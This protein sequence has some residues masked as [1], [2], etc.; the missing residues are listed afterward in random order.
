MKIKENRCVFYDSEC[1]FCRLFAKVIIFFSKAF[2][3]ELGVYSLHSEEVSEFLEKQFGNKEEVPFSFYFVDEKKIYWGQN[4][5]SAIVAYFNLPNSL[6]RFYP[7]VKA[8]VDITKKHNN[9]GCKCKESGER[10]KR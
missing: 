3:K 7:F 10:E 5:A 2:K 9:S 6:H 8:I 4:A 1:L